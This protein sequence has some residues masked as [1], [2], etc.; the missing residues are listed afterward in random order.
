MA[1][2]SPVNIL[3]VDDHAE[4]LLALEAIL[5][6]LGEQLVFAHSGAKALKCLLQ[7][8]FAAIL[9]DV[10]MP[11]MDGFETAALIRGRTRSQSTPIIFLTAI[12]KSETHVFQ[13]YSLGA[14]DYLFKPL[15]PE[16]LRS[17]VAVFVDLYRKTEE[18]RHQAQ[19][20]RETV[21]ELEHQ[22]GER[23][24][25]EAALQRAHDEL[26]LRVEE[27]TAGL[28]A[29]NRALQAEIWER[30]RAQRGLWFLA[31]AGRLLTTSLDYQNTLPEVAALAVPTIADWF[32][33]D[34]VGE[35]GTPERIV[36]IPDALAQ[37]DHPLPLPMA[38]IPA[39]PLALQ[40]STLTSG[41]RSVRHGA[42]RGWTGVIRASVELRGQH[43]GQ[44]LCATAAERGYDEADQTLIEA[45]ARRVAAALDNAR[46]FQE[47][48]EALRARD[49]FLS[50]AAHEL[51]TP[52]TVLVG[53]IEVLR[54]RVEREGGLEERNLRAL[55]VVGDHSN[56]LNRMITSLLDLSRIETGQ[57]SIERH[58]VEVGALL[59]RLVEE[60]QPM[61][62]QHHLLLRCPE[63]PLLI[64]G[65]EL[66]LNQVLHNLIQN[67]V[68]YS[69]PGSAIHLDLRRSGKEAIIA[70]QDEGIGIPPDALPQLFSRFY[71]APNIDLQRVGG[72][73]IGLY[74]VKEIVTLHG[75]EVE[76]ES[77][78]GEGST[79]SIRLPLA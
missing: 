73:G 36:E 32:A 27:R 35:A 1:S 13:G 65:D 47:A 43:L 64:T 21:G 29:A 77:V 5:S 48:K 34:L 41:K 24:R 76:V 28:A 59:R 62:E 25:A 55:Q 69:Q 37:A 51:K 19:R 8:D 12:N 3:L 72:M 40:R 22:I 16:V 57:L 2:N 33:I 46:L 78:E 60:T 20:L 18:V 9:L 79:F 66:R 31:E 67:A 23:R 70:V 11:D 15:V 38:E 63:E 39:A 26:E 49:T 56:R 10:Q 54:R 50:I 44:I 30:E 71:R 6:P 75:G 17:K 68:K 7:Q 4:N 53:Y 61:L 52:L 14:V 42:K 58:E 74:V 45:L